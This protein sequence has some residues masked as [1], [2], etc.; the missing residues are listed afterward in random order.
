[1]HS[2][3]ERNRFLLAFAA[4]S[5]LMGVS[6]GLA[7]MATSLYSLALGAN[8]TMLGMISA[9]QMVGILVM[10]LP[11][12]FLV[13]R[14][15]PRPLFLIGSALAGL[16]YVAIPWIPT[17]E[18]LLLCTLVISFFM[19]LRFIS[20]NTIFM[21][22]LDIVGVSKAGWYRGSHMLGMFL[23]G[24]VIAPP[25]I[26]RFDFNGIFYLIG[27]I[28]ALTII[29]SPMVLNSYGGKAVAHPSPAAPRLRSQLAL[30]WSHPGLRQVSLIEFFCHGMNMFYSFF[31]V[32]IAINDLHLSMVDATGLVAVQ[33][34]TYVLALFFMGGFLARSSQ[35]NAYLS[36]FA[37]ICAALGVLGNAAT[38]PLL[39][40]GAALLG[41]ASGT[42]EVVNLT[43]FAR[44]GAQIGRGKAAAVNALA[45]PGGSLFASLIGGPLGYYLSL[46]TVFI[47][48]IPAWLMLYVLILRTEPLQAGLGQSF[49]ALLGLGQRHRLGL[50]VLAIALI[51]LIL[52][53]SFPAVS[54]TAFEPFIAGIGHFKDSLTY[55][56]FSRPQH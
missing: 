50:T 16:A 40:F 14:V 3:F 18:F 2:F 7:K 1:M 21:Q 38:L 32:V 27:V 42:L 56:L 25:L 31:I 11:V 10:G 34:L 48:F 53:I 54:K 46:Q 20:L 39:W 47:L 45:G 28:F 55:S 13:D 36:C 44:I 8:E 6:V 9:A 30:L 29:L 37:V 22:Q 33:G 41:L 24:P 23:L 26:E 17:A 52:L 43:R 12:G 35:K 19:P 5:S 4:L 49:M 51:P 15:G